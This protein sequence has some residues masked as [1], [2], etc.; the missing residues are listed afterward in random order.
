MKINKEI[1]NILDQS[2]ISGNKLIL[3]LNL[4]RKLY[5][6][7]NEVIELL[8]GKWNKKEKAHLFASEEVLTSKLENVLLTEETENPKDFGFFPTPKNIVLQLLELADLKPNMLVLEPSAGNGA[9][10]KEIATTNKVDC[11]EILEDNI[12]K[13]NT[14]NIYN[15]VLQKDFLTCEPNPVYD[16]VIM[17][18]PFSKQADID[19]IYHAFKYLKPNGKLISIMSSSV[20]FRTN[21]KTTEFNDFVSMNN[22]EIIPLPEK[23]F[24]DSGTNVNTVIVCLMK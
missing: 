20:L 11:I 24:V 14:E 23:S 3:P 5:I 10:A 21:K 7:T 16:R 18:P 4:D 2:A 6:K 15:S 13:L 12:S 9:I 1:L 22:G 19:H 17:N 8:G